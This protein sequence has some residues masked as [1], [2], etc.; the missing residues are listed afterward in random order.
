MIIDSSKLTKSEF[1]RVILDRD[2]RNIYKAQSLIVTRNTYIRKNKKEKTLKL[3]TKQKGGITRRTGTLD[4]SLSSPN[5]FMKSQG[6]EFILQMN[7]PLYIRFLDMRKKSNL[8][9]YNRQ[10]WGIVYNN[11]IPD[12]KYGYGN[13]LRDFVGDMLKEAFN[14]KK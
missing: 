7:Y 5:Y 13:E 2:A 6:S 1:I 10:I 14:T 12:I 11:T 4:K 8:Q 3:T 9:V